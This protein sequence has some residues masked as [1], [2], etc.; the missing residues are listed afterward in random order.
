[1]CLPLV[2]YILFELIFVQLAVLQNIANL[3]QLLIAHFVAVQLFDLNAIN[4]FK[5]Y[6]IAQ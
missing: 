6:S 1:M 3:T 2:A 5:V 4:I